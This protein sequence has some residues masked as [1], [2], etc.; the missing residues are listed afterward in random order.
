MISVTA[1][2]A[3]TI[4][5]FGTM[6]E[7]TLAGPAVGVAD[8]AK[9][10]LQAA[11]V[12][13]PSSSK[14]GG[15]KRDITEAQIDFLFH[16]C[17][18]RSAENPPTIN[19]DTAT[20]SGDITNLPKECMQAFEVYNDEINSEQLGHA[21]VKITGTTSVHVDSIPRQFLNELKTKFGKPIAPLAAMPTN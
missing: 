21:K 14:Q 10:G 4:I 3:V 12:L 17:F 16:P 18:K 1:V 13:R 8:A 15:H 6:I 7:P 9:I 20:N 5:A 11:S 19:Y 2:S